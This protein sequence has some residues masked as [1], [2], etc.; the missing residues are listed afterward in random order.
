MSNKQIYQ[1]RSF[2]VG[3]NKRTKAW[4]DI[5]R[6]NVIAVGKAG[7]SSLK[8]MYNQEVY[9]QDYNRS[10]NN[11]NKYSKV[12]G[13]VELMIPHIHE[14]GTIAYWGDRII[15]KHNPENL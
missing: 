3:W 11:W 9:R 14:D 7:L 12:Q 1:L 6:K 5:D 2:L 4:E 8:R 10:C 15:L 13:K